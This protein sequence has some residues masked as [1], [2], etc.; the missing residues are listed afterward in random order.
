MRQRS[1]IRVAESLQQTMILGKEQL[2]A[3]KSP[4]FAFDV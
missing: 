3:Y 1:V 4:T 2:K